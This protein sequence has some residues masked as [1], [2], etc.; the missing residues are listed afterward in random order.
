MVTAE[1]K[2]RSGHLLP[3]AAVALCGMAWG[4]F[5]YPLRW[6]EDLGVGGAW[7]SLIFFAVAAA[8][9]LPWLFRKA[10]WRD[11]LGSQF[12]TG[13]LLGTAFTLYT[14][15]LVMTD[16]I[17]AILLF[18]LTPVW[19]TIGGLMFLRERMTLAR[20][21]SMALG[22]AGMMFILGFEEGLP[23]PRNAGDWVALA[24]G[25]LW[26]AGTLRSFARPSSGIAMPVFS[27]SIGGL[28][29]SGV[30]LIIAAMISSPLASISNL[31]P[32]LPWIVLLALIIFVPPNF[33]VLWAA[34]RID[35][36]RVGILLMTEV[37][38][39]S[40]TAALFSGE[41]FGLRELAGT[42]LIVVAA[43]TEVLGRR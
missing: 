14:V 1:Q 32:T 37:L 28:V 11:R 43:L 6:F 18:Y 26:A 10:H 34:Q 35:S 7:V 36:G 33:L 4:G 19:S 31:A 17:H 2:Q 12:F 8:S 23:L 27:F 29:S 21:L 16:V 15:S 5:W 25:M 20:G 24:S 30:V 38:A 40:I 3:S 42:T 39:G 9:P 22:F 41:P 13:L